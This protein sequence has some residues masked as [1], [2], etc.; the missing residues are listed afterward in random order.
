M[1]SFQ[2][3]KRLHSSLQEVG[4]GG[5]ERKTKKQKSFHREKFLKPLQQKKDRINFCSETRFASNQ[6]SLQQDLEKI[7]GGPFSR[8]RN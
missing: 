7:L 6:F 2:C 1:L 5:Q 8:L 3:S 4:K